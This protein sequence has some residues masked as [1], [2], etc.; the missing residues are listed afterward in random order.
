MPFSHSNRKSVTSGGHREDF[1]RERRKK[2]VLETGAGTGQQSFGKKE[3]SAAR[4]NIIDYWLSQ[5]ECQ[6]V[7]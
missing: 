6:L 2:P 1:C 7:R 5:R 4:L 3:T